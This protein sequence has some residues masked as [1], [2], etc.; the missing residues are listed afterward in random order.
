MD[1]IKL[2]QTLNEVIPNWLDYDE[3][4]TIEL[5][6]ESKDIAVTDD[7]SNMI[8]ALKTCCTVETPWIS[9]YVFENVVDAFSGNI[10]IPETLTLPP[11]E[12]IMTTVTIMMGIREFPFSTEIA[13]YIATIAVKEGLMA[14]PDP[15][16]F[17]N[18][19]I[20]NDTYGLKDEML[21]R[22]EDIA[23]IPVDYPYEE[24]QIGI[25]LA[26]LSALWSEYMRRTGRE[27]V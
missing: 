16:A 23:N 25:Q 17:A 11:L 9:P 4:E 12:D 24:S 5:L 22:V 15:I 21:K 10:V 1:I 2:Y 7:I 14:L 13:K 6:L 20:P 18:E 26:K 3:P 27:L 8:N 19:F